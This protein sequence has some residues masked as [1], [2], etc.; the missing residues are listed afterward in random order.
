MR[1]RG[2]KGSRCAEM[3]AYV[4]L[5]V[6]KQLG[7]KGEHDALIPALCHE[8]GSISLLKGEDFIRNLSCIVY[9]GDVFC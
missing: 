4:C 5:L 7:L 1:N 6:S 9:T 3:E 2:G 8:K